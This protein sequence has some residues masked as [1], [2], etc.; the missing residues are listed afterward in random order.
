MEKCHVAS[1]WTR[2]ECSLQEVEHV[3]VSC[4]VL[5]CEI[6]CRIIGLVL[7]LLQFQIESF[8]S[9]NLRFCCQGYNGLK[10]QIFPAH[11]ILRSTNFRTRFP[12]ILQCSQNMNFVMTKPK[13]SARS[14][15]SLWC[16]LETF[17][18]AFFGQPPSHA[19]SSLMKGD[20]DFE[21]YI[22]MTSC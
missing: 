15:I 3:M 9:F 7:F 2:I 12:G 16:R 10:W 17:T 22:S 4:T 21:L 8:N 6:T 11:W 18:I 1:D 20:F 14:T 19:K 5:K 13:R